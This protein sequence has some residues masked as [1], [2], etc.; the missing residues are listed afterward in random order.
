MISLINKNLGDKYNFFKKY[1]LDKDYLSLKSQYE[2]LPKENI[3]DIQQLTYSENNNLI[4][5]F[6]KFNL[7]YTT[8]NLLVMLHQLNMT[9]F[10]ILDTETTG[11][12]LKSD[13]PFQIAWL[14]VDYDFNIIEEF[15][16]FVDINNPEYPVYPNKQ[17][18]TTFNDINERL[19]NI[20]A[21]NIILVG[22]NIIFD[23]SMLNN[24]GINLSFLQTYDTYQSRFIYKNKLLPNNQLS[25]VAQSFGVNDVSNAH[26]ALFDC[27]MVLQ[28]LKGLRGEYF[29]I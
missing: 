6:H 2:Q 27:K 1:I 20:I 11:L 15:S 5:N 14:L 19:N 12:N 9:K 4:Y 25:T 29:A 22:H 28:V 3:N 24:V 8:R 21:D 13:I 17:F 23:I 18:V 26:E 7:N 16:G 10:L